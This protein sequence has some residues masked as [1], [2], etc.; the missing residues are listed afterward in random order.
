MSGRRAIVGPCAVRVDLSAASSRAG[1]ASPT[2]SVIAVRRRRPDVIGSLPAE[3]VDPT[4]WPLCP[5]FDGGVQ[6]CVCWWSQR[7]DEYLKGGGVWP[8]GERCQL[9][10]FLEMQSRFPCREPWDPLAI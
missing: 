1:D 8:G 5:R 7:Q 2:S 3:L 4:Q 9:T 6:R 10:D